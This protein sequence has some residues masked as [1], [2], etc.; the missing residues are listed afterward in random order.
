MMTCL[1]IEECDMYPS[2]Y[3]RRDVEVLLYYNI[4]IGLR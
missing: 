1:D 3:I 4:L 2:E